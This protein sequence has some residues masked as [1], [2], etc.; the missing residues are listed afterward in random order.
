MKA[1]SIIIDARQSTFEGGIRTF[2]TQVLDFNANNYFDIIKWDDISK[3]TPP[4]ILNFY[5]NEQLL[6]ASENPLNIPTYPC[7]TQA[8]ERTIKIVTHATETVYGHEERNGLI[9]NILKNKE[10]YKSFFSKEEYYK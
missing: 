1:A 5:S 6:S 9:L 7:H 10:K 3:V 8:F 4:P 2:E